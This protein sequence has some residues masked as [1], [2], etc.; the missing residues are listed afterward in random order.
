MNLSLIDP[1][2]LSLDYPDTTTASLRSGHSTCARFN[3]SG[4]LLASGRVDGTV[5]I[6][7]V[8]TLGVARKLRGHSK[9]IQS[10]SWSR[11]GRFLLSAG[12]DW[13][14]VLWDLETGGVEK[15]WRCTGMVYLAELS[16]ADDRLAVLSLFDNQ[17]ILV[18]LRNETSYKLS[19]MP[20]RTHDDGEKLSDKQ[21]A[22][23]AKQT[24]TVAIFTASGSH[25]I[26]GTSKGWLNIIE[27]A[28]RTTI[29][30][31]KISS[32]VIIYLRLTSSGRDMVV[33]AQDRVIRT[34]HLPPLDDPTLE[35]DQIHMEIEHKFQDVVNRLS[36][37]HVAFS[38]SGE[39]VMASTYNNHDIYI[40]ERNHGSLVKILEGPK[41]EHGVVEWHPNRPLIAACGLESGRIHIWSI[42]SP[43]R[44]S[45]LAPDFVEVEENVEYE[46]AEDE[47]DIHPE[48]ERRQQQLDGENEIVDVQTVGRKV[49]G[50]E[51]WR[52]PVLLDLGDA[53]SEDE[54]VMVATG[55]MR[56][57]KSVV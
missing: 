14:V 50:E 57:R 4:N 51:S 1:F 39:Y 36:W 3:R 29:Y 10:L 54:F 27:T 52:M 55:T 13:K 23:D 2:V 19:S 48:E 30:S 9:Q 11:D 32:G 38:G 12:Q 22:Q 44:W 56:D 16:G 20:K 35:P 40:W 26:A 28:T 37:N 21:V 17:P 42:I 41:E 25:I 6:I 53:V 49:E 45:A 5:A 33:N 46:E 34:I 8:E 43:Q 24:T 31:T 15:E 18:D 7:D 47:F